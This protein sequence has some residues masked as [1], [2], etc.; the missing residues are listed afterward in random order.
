M[1]T[2]IV[3]PTR[4]IGVR[5]LKQQA[6][7]I[8]TRVRVKGEEIQITYRGQVIARIVPT[9]R[10]RPATRKKLG[11]TW[12]AMDQLAAEIGAA[13]KTKIDVVRDLRRDL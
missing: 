6:S 3:Q 7:A 13:K 12:A 11:A 9:L 2:Q 5:E 10:P 4:T 8:L 1:Q